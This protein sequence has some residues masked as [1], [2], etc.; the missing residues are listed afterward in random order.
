M[1]HCQENVSWNGHC[2][3][4]MWNHWQMATEELP[5]RIWSCHGG[6]SPL[7]CVNKYFATGLWIWRALRPLD[8]TWT[9][10]SLNTRQ[11]HLRVWLTMAQFKNWCKTWIIHPRFV[12]SSRSLFHYQLIMKLLVIHMQLE[13]FSMN[14]QIGHSHEWIPDNRCVGPNIL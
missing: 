6:Q 8:L 7:I 1:L 12:L 2:V 13:W 10:P 4:L 14:L 11:T 5:R 3:H 9:T